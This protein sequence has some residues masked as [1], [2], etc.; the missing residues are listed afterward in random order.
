MKPSIIITGLTLCLVLPAS[1]DE[2]QDTQ[3]QQLFERMQTLEKESHQ[4]RITILEQAQACI[5]QAQNFREHRKCKEQE[6]LARQDFKKNHKLQKQAL[7]ED[8]RKLRRN[9]APK[10]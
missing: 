2:R 1:A 3:K 8:I 9:R 10:R 6:K 7:R 4:Q 5:N